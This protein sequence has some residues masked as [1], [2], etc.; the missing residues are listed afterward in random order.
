MIEMFQ[1]VRNGIVIAYFELQEEAEAF[2]INLAHA[3]KDGGP[4]EV[5]NPAGKWVFFYDMPATA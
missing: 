4:V 5:L 1:V 2:A 3:E